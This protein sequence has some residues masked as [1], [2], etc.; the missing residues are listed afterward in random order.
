MC[1]LSKTSR[2]CLFPPLSCKKKKQK[3]ITQKSGPP[4]KFFTQCVAFFYFIFFLKCPG[5]AICCILVEVEEEE[6]ERRTRRRSID[7][8]Y[9]I[10]QIWI[11]RYEISYLDFIFGPIKKLRREKKKGRPA[12]GWQQPATR[13]GTG[14]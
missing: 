6:K 3:K 4:I 7:S 13:L 8:S 11:S 9:P 12:G 1:W 14:C 2:V 10:S 5:F